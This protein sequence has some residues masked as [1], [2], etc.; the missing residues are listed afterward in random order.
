[1]DENIYLSH[2][3]NQVKHAERLSNIFI[4]VNGFCAEGAKSFL[5]QYLSSRS[6]RVQSIAVPEFRELAP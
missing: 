5:G 6:V 2:F 4:I 1:M 3:T